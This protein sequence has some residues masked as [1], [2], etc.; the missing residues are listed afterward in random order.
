MQAK[1]RKASLPAWR[2]AKIAG[3]DKAQHAL[4]FR[5]LPQ[6]EIEPRMRQIERSARGG[7]LALNRRREADAGGCVTSFVDQREAYA[8]NDLTR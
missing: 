1:A 8:I 4:I 6:C 5:D 3:P 7:G 2:R